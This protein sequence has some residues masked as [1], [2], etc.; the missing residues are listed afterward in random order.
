MALNSL[1]VHVAYLLHQ[2]EIARF[3]GTLEAL[4]PD[5][6]GQ[7]VCR[8]PQGKLRCV[9]RT[10][11]IMGQ[12]GANGSG[13][14]GKIH[15]GDGQGTTP[16]LSDERALFLSLFKSGMLAFPARA[17]DH[18]TAWIQEKTGP[19]RAVGLTYPAYWRKI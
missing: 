11:Q 18:H 12:A 15:A 19:I 4:P 7:S 13:I 5:V 8:Q 2:G 10:V 6:A 3:L 9:S 1:Y 17:W 14:P 16:Q